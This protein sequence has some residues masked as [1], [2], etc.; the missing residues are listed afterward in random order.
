M[1]KQKSPKKST[2]IVSTWGHLGTSG[3]IGEWESRSSGHKVKGKDRKS[4]NS[5]LEISQP[6]TDPSSTTTS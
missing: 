3:L 4:Q 2:L 1:I 5:S 6:N